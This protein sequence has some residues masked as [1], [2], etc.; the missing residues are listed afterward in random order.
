MSPFVSSLFPN[1]VRIT[2][3][4]TNALRVVSGVPNIALVTC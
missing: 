1:I 2:G 4:N 3:N